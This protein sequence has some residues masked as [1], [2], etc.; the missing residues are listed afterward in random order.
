MTDDPDRP[1][2]PDN[3]VPLFARPLRVDAQTGKLE[4]CSPASEVDLG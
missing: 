1:E 4:S 2:P 3:I